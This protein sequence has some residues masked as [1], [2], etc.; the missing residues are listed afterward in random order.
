[1]NIIR[2]EE[3]DVQAIVDKWAPVLDNVL[4]REG[5]PQINYTEDFILYCCL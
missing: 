1:M 2:N 3:L 5:T 4:H